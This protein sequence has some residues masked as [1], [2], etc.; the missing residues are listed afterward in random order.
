MISSAFFH[1]ISGGSASCMDFSKSA[2]TEF[3]KKIMPPVSLPAAAGIERAIP[4]SALFLS[5]NRPPMLWTQ[6]LKHWHT[7]SYRIPARESWQEFKKIWSAF[8]KNACSN[9][10]Y[11]IIYP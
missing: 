7:P 4:S 10:A 11:M 5:P 1:E 8:V 9:I 2:E 6:D 3:L